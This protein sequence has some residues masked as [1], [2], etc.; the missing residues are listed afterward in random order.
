MQVFGS[1]LLSLFLELFKLQLLLVVY[2]LVSP[3]LHL[4]FQEQPVEIVNNVF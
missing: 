4:Q 3:A 2:R 1:L